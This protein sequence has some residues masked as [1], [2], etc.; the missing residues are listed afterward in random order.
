MLTNIARL[1]ATQAHTGQV[2]K[3]TNEPYI[4]HP[5]RVAQWLARF[6]VGE[7]IEAG[8]ICHDVLEDTG[9][10]YPAL[11]L[12]V[13]TPV[14]DLVLEVTNNEYP[15]GTSRTQ[16]F[17]GNIIKLL[18]ASHQAQ[19]LKCGDIWDNC[20]DVY[21]NDPVYG[22]RYVAEKFFLVCLFTRAQADVK[23]EVLN[24]LN[25]I[26]HNRMTN[27]HRQYAWDYLGILDRECPEEYREFYLATS[28]EA[29]RQQAKGV[30]VFGE[31]HEATAI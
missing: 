19:T 17:W 23:R 14:A 9:V 13:G 30:L 21:E 5:L 2:R 29:L 20:R 15:E 7:L 1:V 18:N 12:T 16:K 3:Y 22:C 26:Y 28:R 25:D 6:N 4:N 27:E 24:L 11:E 8:A 31:Y 10:G